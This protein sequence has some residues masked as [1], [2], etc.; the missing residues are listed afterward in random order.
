MYMIAVRNIVLICYTLDDSNTL[1]NECGHIT[2]QHLRE[3]PHCHSKNVDYLT[4]II[5]YLKRVSNFS[6]DRQKEAARRYYQRVE[7]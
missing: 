4:R 5:G 3:C 1:C 7:A 2:K 6:L